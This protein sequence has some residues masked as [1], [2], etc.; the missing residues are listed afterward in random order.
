MDKL[1]WP[2]SVKETVTAFGSATK[3]PFHMLIKKKSHCN[4]CCFPS[5]FIPF[6][7]QQ[8]VSFGREKCTGKLF[9]F[10]RRT[11]CCKPL[12]CN[13]S[14]SA[15][16]IICSVN[17]RAL[18]NFWYSNEQLYFALFQTIPVLEKK[19]T[20]GRKRADNR[21]WKVWLRRIWV[22]FPQ[23]WI[24]PKSHFCNVVSVLWTG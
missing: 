1:H 6:N 20:L 14:D 2:N 10:H 24:F 9:A 21:F 11:V 3:V 7:R 18:L 22:I 5:D 15:K 17:I 13:V 16:A 4:L 8:E 23:T 19:R 12:T